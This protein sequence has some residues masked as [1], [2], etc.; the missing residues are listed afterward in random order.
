MLNQTA[1][2]FPKINIVCKLILLRN[3]YPFKEFEPDRVSDRYL[4]YILSF[5]NLKYFT[6]KNIWKLEAVTLEEK[7]CRV[8]WLEIFA[9]NE[10]E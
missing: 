9:L 7:L 1:A 8:N 6:S 5:E 2:L 3:G 10:V 4:Q